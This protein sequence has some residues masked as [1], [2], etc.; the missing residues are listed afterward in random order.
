MKLQITCPTKTVAL[1]Q[2]LLASFL[3]I[4]CDG[5]KADSVFPEYN[6]QQIG[7]LTRLDKECKIYREISNKIEKKESI[8]N[9]LKKGVLGYIDTTGLFIEWVGIL[10]SYEIESVAYPFNAGLDLDGLEIHINLKPLDSSKVRKIAFESNITI[11]RDRKDTLL[12][13][14]QL[15]DLKLGDTILLDGFIQKNQNKEIQFGI[16][17]ITETTPCNSVFSF[18]PISIQKAGGM[19]EFSEP[20]K[21]LR[22]DLVQE[23]VK[24]ALGLSSSGNFRQKVSSVYNKAQSLATFERKYLCSFIHGIDLEIDL[25]MEEIKL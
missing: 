6:T 24:L 14:N 21:L 2:L 1:L 4:G 19:S 23:K 10:E 12:V 9:Y 8:D 5:E 11:N 3:F 16:Q 22:N 15:K 25:G 20:F 17:G 18:Y 13:Y 7:F